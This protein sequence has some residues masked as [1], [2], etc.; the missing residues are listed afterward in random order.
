MWVVSADNKASQ[1]MVEVAP[2]RIGADAV[3]LKGLEPG[4]RIVV[5]GVQ[6][7]REGAPVQPKTAEE[8]AQMTAA[9]AAKS[10]EVSEAKK[11]ETKPAKH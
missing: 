7:L 4:E 5:E 6:K 8:V 2:I 10:A 1:R 9:Q 3:I 11:G